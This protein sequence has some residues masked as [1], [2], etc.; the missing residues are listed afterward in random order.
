MAATARPDAWHPG[1]TATHLPQVADSKSLQQGHQIWPSLLS[2]GHIFC[3]CR[4]LEER[5]LGLL[6]MMST[7]CTERH[8]LWSHAATWLP[9]CPGQSRCASWPVSQH[10]GA[11]VS[12]SASHSMPAVC[13]HCSRHGGHSSKQQR[14]DLYSPGAAASVKDRRTINE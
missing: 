14:S 9:W 11:F 4:Q 12:S 7:E 3:L 6:L 13:L 5:F 10:L 2:H 1:H 8:M